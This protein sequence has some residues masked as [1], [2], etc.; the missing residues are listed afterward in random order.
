MS[1]IICAFAGLGKT[2]LSQKYSN[3]IDFDLQK[4]KY[5]CNENITNFEKYK[6]LNNK[7]INKEWPQ[8]YMKKLKEIMSKDKIILVPADEEVRQLLVLENI[9]F[10]FV[11]PSLDSKDNLVER[12]IERGNSE[13]FIQRAILN[14]IDWHHLKYKYKTI[15]LKKNEYLED[16]LLRENLIN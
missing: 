2:Y 5:I 12:Y 16:Y 8:N 10:V 13:D 11:L 7:I 1:K 6:G 9:S 4:F 3:V 14:L 15:I